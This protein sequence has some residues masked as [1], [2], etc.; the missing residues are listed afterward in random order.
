MGILDTLFGTDAA[1][2]SK[3]AAAD[4]YA[5]QQAAG[6]GI[7]AY[8][9]QYADKFR[10]LADRYTPYTTAGGVAANQ[11]TN[12]LMDP[13][14]VRSLPGYEFNRSEGM[15]G[16]ENSAA[17]RSGILNGKTLKDIDRFNS[18]YAD[19]MYGNH[20]A[21]LMG[22]TGQGAAATGAAVNTEGTG[23]QGQLATRQ[24][25]YGGDMK[26]A[27]TIG[28]GDIAAANAKTSALQNLI[29]AGVSLGGA[30]LGGGVG[31]SSGNILAKL[32]GGGASDYGG[33]TP[34]QQRYW[35]SGNVGPVNG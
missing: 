14:N 16:V 8:G 24:S 29:N 23:L 19:T 21:R 20:F 32:F 10:T 33:V 13:S 34:A 6:A 7:R 4:T 22:A 5:K 12:L 3:A 15:R 35:N 11:F 9:D 31:G 17:A 1:R 26:A 2:A 30:A 28:Q 25:A 27:E 18:N